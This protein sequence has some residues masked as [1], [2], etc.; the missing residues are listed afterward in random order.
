MS[1]RYRDGSYGIDHPNWHHEDA[2]AKALGVLPLLRDLPPPARVVDVGCGAGGVLWH[3][4]QRLGAE[5]SA[6][7]WEGWD[8][9]PR[10]IEQ[11][12]GRAGRALRFRTGDFL[13]SDATADLL[14]CLDVVEHVPDDL[15][16]LAAL[17]SRAERFLFRLPLDLS[18]W[19]VARP[20]P[21]LTQVGPRFG[22]RHLYTRELALQRLEA[23]GYVIDD[24]RYH[25]AEPLG[26]GVMDRLRRRGMAWRP[27]ATVRWLG[28][29]SLLV[30]ARA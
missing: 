17:R 27:H 30:R 10:A 13:A 24:V 14:L 12:E 16:F 3:L 9:A 21:R 23:A 8:V 28:G 18:V 5:W 25:R 11:A 1:D 26:R 6:T 19:D 22:H 20:G 2:E 29:F 15:A 4:Q 7:A